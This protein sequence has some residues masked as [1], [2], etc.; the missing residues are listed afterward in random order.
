MK[1]RILWPFLLFVFGAVVLNACG[2]STQESPTPVP[3]PAPT[4]S[5]PAIMAAGDISCDSATPQL[6]CKSRETS[7]LILSERALR[8]GLVVL[9]LGDLQYESGTLAEFLKN[10]GA[11]WGRLNA[12]AHP[13]PGNHEYETRNATGY[14]DYFAGVGVG[15]GARTEGWYSYDVAD[16][17]FIALNSNCASIG[18]CNTGSAQY[19]WLQ[20]DLLAHKQKCT[21]AYMHHPFQASGPNGNTPEL[22]PFMRLLYENNADIVLSGHEHSYER[23]IPIT[24]DLVPDAVKGL[25]L[26]V[27]GTGGRDLTAFVRPPV[28]HSAARTNEYFGALR[29]VMKSGAYE[30][31]FLNIA[32]TVIDSGDGVCF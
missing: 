26:F 1:F 14:F 27:V 5:F 13:A 7:D 20:S 3:T 17:H 25:R 9:P 4:P 31:A 32:G 30:W 8:P 28:A 18:G 16:W 21:V 15:V 11:T 24:P 2:G 29:I 10:Y 12:L 6:P 23:F 19:R 22:L